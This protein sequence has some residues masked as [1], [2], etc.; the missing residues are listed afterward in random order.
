[1]LVHKNANVAGPAAQTER[2]RLNEAGAACHQDAEMV[3]F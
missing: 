2:R 1:M 3:P